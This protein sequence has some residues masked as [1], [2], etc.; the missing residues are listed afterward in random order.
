MTLRLPGTR[1][2]VLK[3]F[4]KLQDWGKLG[5]FYKGVTDKGVIRF[6]AQESR[7]AVA[8]NAAK[9][10]K[11]LSELNGELSLAL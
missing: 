9:L 10:M 3:F 5:E 7:E 11:P 4:G 6:A 1:L 2:P 8:T